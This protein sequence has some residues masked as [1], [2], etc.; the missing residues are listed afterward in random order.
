[1]R[2]HRSDEWI[3]VPWVYRSL[4]GQPFGLA[5]W[6]HARRVS[7]E[8][9]GLRPAE[10]DVARDVADLL[11]RASSQNLSAEEA[12]AV[13]VDTSRPARPKPEASEDPA[14]P[15]EPEEDPEQPEADIVA[16][17]G[18]YDDAGLAEQA[19]DPQRGP[20]PAFVV[21][22]DPVQCPHDQHLELA[23]VRVGKLLLES[24]LVPLAA[25]VLPRRVAELVPQPD[26]VM[27]GE[28]LGVG[29]LVG[30]RLVPGSAS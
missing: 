24:A 3:T 26:P 8:R 11:K 9:S 20:G 7:T 16:A 14:P 23:G 2:D 27:A 22:D 4:A 6:E 13:A 1:M 25:A 10:A 17:P 12:K 21:A 30:R 15:P 5:L 28:P 29:H 19:D 18:A